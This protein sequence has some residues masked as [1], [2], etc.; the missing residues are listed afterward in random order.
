MNISK[1]KIV[2]NYL[3]NV[4]YQIV[5]TIL[6]VVTIPYL[7][8]VLG[9][10][11]LGIAR[12]VESVVSIFIVF[13]MLGLV[14]Y[15][16]RAVAYN[17]QDKFKLSQCF[18]E[19]FFMRIVLMVATLFI[20]LLFIRKSVY[21][22]F[23]E[24]Y[25]I[26]IIGSFLDVGWF[27]TGIEEM[28]PIVIRNYIIRIISTILLFCLVKS[29]D[30]LKVY[31]WLICLTTMVNAIAVFPWIKKYVVPI[32]LRDI[33]FVLFLPQA[34]SQLYVQ[35]D[36]IMIENLVPNISYVSYYTENEKIAKLPIILVTALSTVLMP[37]I[38]YEFS[39]GREAHIKEYIRKAL[40]IT[41][42]VLFPCCLGMMATA[43]NFIPIFLGREFADTYGILIMLCPIMIF[44]G[45]SNVT[46]IQYLVAVDK[47]K[48][49]II[50]YL[51]ALMIN[52]VINY[53][54]IPRY[55]AYGAAVGTIAA[56]GVSA[57]IQYYCMR[58]D[59][60]KMIEVNWIL[61]VMFLSCAMG[62]IVYLLNFIKLQQFFILIL[63]VMLGVIIY[64]I[65]TF[66]LNLFP[67]G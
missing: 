8:R 35:C 65:G 58:K 12:Y 36:K 49:L 43:S 24:I 28:K 22:I 40:Q 4:S 7:T 16:N 55:N 54:L 61:K 26:H 27:F 14:W 53:L 30:D 21:K 9:G 63:Q 38:A 52:I 56:E 34:A 29:K 17:R 11:S 62:I 20:Y 15:A 23:F 48:E 64:I 31:V 45:I 19:I 10:N 42:Y 50:S 47:K 46:G 51:S 13:G 2:Q 39:T 1:N 41:C 67:R 33:H 60:G 44:I 66:G 5:M 6:P 59:L 37:R 3:Y 18:W 32:P 25:V 57:I